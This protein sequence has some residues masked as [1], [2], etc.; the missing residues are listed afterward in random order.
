MVLARGPTTALATATF[1][2]ASHA[3]LGCKRG[4]RCSSA[5]TLF[6]R[7]TFST[8]SR[9]LATNAAPGDGGASSRGSSRGAGPPR[10]AQPSQPAVAGSP[11][12]ADTSPSPPLR[13]RQR[14]DVFAVALPV[15]VLSPV[16]QVLAVGFLFVAVEVHVHVQVVGPRGHLTLPP[17]SPVEGGSSGLPAGRLGRGAHPHCGVHC[18]AV[19]SALSGGSQPGAPSPSQIGQLG[20]FPQQSHAPSGTTRSPLRSTSCS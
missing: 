7:S 11:G 5:W 6:S 18:P 20:C 3:G 10:R 13:G 12:L 15:D 16:T 2:L 14:L 19:K 9:V 17:P 4:S 8:A 1:S